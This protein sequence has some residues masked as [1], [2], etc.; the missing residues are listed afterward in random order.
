MSGTLL[1]DIH[2]KSPSTAQAANSLVRAFLAGIG[3]AFVQPS[4]DAIGVGWTFT[5]FGGL[6][7]ACMGFA[8]LEYAFGQR[9]RDKKKARGVER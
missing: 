2:P 1:V 3:I 5:L 9:W 6:G 8:W 4:I 7:M